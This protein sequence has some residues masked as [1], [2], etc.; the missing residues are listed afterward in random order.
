MTKQARPANH[1]C[2]SCLF[3]PQHN[4]VQCRTTHHSTDEQLSATGS[5]HW[6]T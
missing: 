6:L 2:R 1:P 4:L 3:D 5:L